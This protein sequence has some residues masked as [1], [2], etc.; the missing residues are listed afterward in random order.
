MRAKE[1]YYYLLYRVNVLNI[2]RRKSGC[3]DRYSRTSKQ[4]KE[5]YYSLMFILAISIQKIYKPSM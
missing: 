5:Y 1:D 2:I 4:N 3:K